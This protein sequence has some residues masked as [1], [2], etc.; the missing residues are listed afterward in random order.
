MT[1]PPP[2]LR[3]SLRDARRSL[4]EAAQ[5]AASSAV[6]L[7]LAP[8][9]ES[10]P[11]T[12]AGYVAADGEVRIGS[13]LDSLRER[14]TTIVLPRMADDRMTFH[15]VGSDEELVPGAWGLT[16]PRADAPVIAPETL[17]IVL[18]PLV[19]FDA[20]RNRI[21]RGRGYYD[22]HFA[23]LN[24]DPRPATPRLIGVAHDLQ[25]VD[26]LPVHDHD[27]RLDAV[28]TPSRLHGALR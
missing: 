4:D 23:F 20:A 19:G 13:T 17:E 5:A 27:V 24:A 16:E 14:G 8:L 6:E 25:L 28:V 3:R 9:L 10:P 26:R 15:V 21:G 1:T 7:R 2:S 11:E 18:T 12:A 22:R